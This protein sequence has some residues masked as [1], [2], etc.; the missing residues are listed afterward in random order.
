MLPLITVLMPVFNADKYLNIAIDSI[1]SQTFSNFEFLIIDDGSTDKSVEIIQAYTDSRIRFIQNVSNQGISATLNKGISLSTTELIA[2]MDAD[3]ICYPERL[4]NQYNFFMADPECALLSTS[5]REISKDGIPLRIN[6]YTKEYYYYNLT[7]IC[8][9]YHPTVMF[10]RSVVLDAGGYSVI[11]SEDFDLWWKII[12]KYK[13]CH[14]QQILLDYRSYSESISAGYK[15]KEYEDFQH[16]QVMR[17]IQ[18]Y[19]GQDFH[20]TYEEIE[21]LRFN[22]S[23]LLVKNNLNEIGS[24]FR[25]LKLLSMSILDKD[26]TNL[27][28]QAVKEAYFHKKAYTLS[29]FQSHLSPWKAGLLLIRSGNFLAGCILIARNFVKFKKLKV[30]VILKK[31]KSFFFNNSQT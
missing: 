31:Y 13:V 8:W 30:Y 9:I 5:V 21:S 25:K 18:F 19:T 27:N 2:R 24:L 11:Y 15:K 17:N 22:F 16:M 20:L 3:D 10:K 14:L 12:R 29:F 1:L 6:N 7:F 4:E 23:P 26:N 28:K